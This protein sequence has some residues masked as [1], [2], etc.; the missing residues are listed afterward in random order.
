[1]TILP[2][3]GWKPQASVLFFVLM[4]VTWLPILF[5]HIDKTT[6]H[7]IFAITNSLSGVW[8][9]FLHCFWDKQ[10]RQLVSGKLSSNPSLTKYVLNWN[11][12]LRFVFLGSWFGV[13]KFDI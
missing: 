2:R 13:L 10:L 1:L 3:C 5:T 4:G 9:F 12:T 11:N 7:Y 6:G 8:L